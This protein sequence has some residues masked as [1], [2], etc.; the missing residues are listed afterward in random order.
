MSNAA[1]SDRP[2]DN[3]ADR[4][5]ETI[6]VHDYG[7]DEIIEIHGRVLTRPG[8]EIKV[9]ANIRTMVLLS[10]SG[11]L[12]VS[13]SH[14][15]D[16]HVQSFEQ[17]IHQQGYPVHRRYTV[18]MKTLSEAYTAI[19]DDSVQK[20][21]KTADT[22]NTRELLRIIRSAADK[23]A[24]DIHLVVDNETATVRMRVDGVMQDIEEFTAA[25][26][27]EL[28]GTAFTMAGTA[29]STYSPFEYQAARI[30][31]QSADL[32][33][34]VQSIRVQW[35]PLSFGGRFMVM[36]MLYSS[37]GGAEEAASAPDLSKLGYR[38]KQLRALERVRA[39][40]MGI[41]IIAGP[42][43][44]G[45]STTVA[46]TLDQLLHECRYEKS[47]LTVEDPPEYQITGAQQMP[48]TNAKTPEQ[49][50]V[51]FQQAIEAALRSDPNIILIGEIR[52][53]DSARLALQGAMTGTQVWTSL[54]ANTALGILDRLRD[55]GVENYK[56]CDPTIVTGLIGQRLLRVLC[57]DCR[58]S[59]KKAEER[60]MI[61]PPRAERTHAVLEA[62]GKPADGVCV[63]G[64]GCPTCNNTGYK[65]RTAAS[66]IIEPDET[67]MEYIRQEDKA[68][69]RKYWLN[70]LGGFTMLTHAVHK[71]IS[72]EVGPIEV[73]SAVDIL[74]ADPEMIHHFQ[75]GGDQ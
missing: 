6:R 16:P 50:M 52:G 71:L 2:K 62:I 9:G 63:R 75:T 74:R 56:L 61:E 58:I 36:R 72:G 3:A 51:K 64:S 46:I 33:K 19:E 30:T 1:Q 44:S 47:C 42:V 29:D 41:N 55:I 57:P 66:E 17:R 59:L 18:D 31:Q 60:E 15:E 8:G 54:H 35:N 20:L 7:T 39:Q 68:S 24:S 67:F 10:E 48:V 25:R 14:V 12:L 37:A 32:P 69:A 27:T 45:K 5:H 23:K 11:E 22:V 49:R 34:N 53:P 40:P 38:P 28:C 13:R 70:D 65:G 26:G 21:K 73:E 4:V 43:N